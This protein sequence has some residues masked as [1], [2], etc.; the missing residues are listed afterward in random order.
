[1]EKENKISMKPVTQTAQHNSSASGN[2]LLAQNRIK[3]R[4]ALKRACKDRQQQMTPVK[5]ASKP[6]PKRQG[7]LV[8][9]SERLQMSAKLQAAKK[10]NTNNNNNNNKNNNERSSSNKN[11]KISVAAAAATKKR[12]PPTPP[13]SRPRQRGPRKSKL[14]V[15]TFHKEDEMEFFSSDSPKKR[16]KEN[17]INAKALKIPDEPIEQTAE[18]QVQLMEPPPDKRVLL[19]EYSQEEFLGLFGLIT[20]EVAKTLSQQPKTKWKRRVTQNKFYGHQGAMRR[21]KTLKAEA[22]KKQ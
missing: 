3:V 21:A 15:R 12:T 11:I 6:P 18:P 7:Y 14:E 9:H 20:H 22:E 13:G 5:T 16:Q 4:E 2:D 10:K 19:S 8:P 17:A 1:M